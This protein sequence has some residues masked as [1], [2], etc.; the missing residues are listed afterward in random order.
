M[1][2]KGVML[3]APNGDKIIHANQLGVVTQFGQPS[4]TSHNPIPQQ[5][6]T[7]VYSHYSSS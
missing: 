5:K 4:N 1:D 6:N 3:S 7:N 2:Y